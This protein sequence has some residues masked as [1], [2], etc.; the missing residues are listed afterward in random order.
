MS[1]WCHKVSLVWFFKIFFFLHNQNCVVT[2]VYSSG[3]DEILKVIAAAPVI[4]LGVK[5]M[6]YGSDL[7]A[8]QFYKAD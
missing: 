1:C 5:A 7:I 2:S 6:F 4:V 8:L 3:L